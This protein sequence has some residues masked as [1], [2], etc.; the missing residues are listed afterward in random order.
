MDQDFQQTEQ[1]EKWRAENNPEAEATSL[2]STIQVLASLLCLLLTATAVSI[3]VL[4]QTDVKHDEE[5]P[6]ACCFS[7]LSK[8]IPLHFLRDY[9]LTS[10]MC[11]LKAV[12]FKTKKNRQAC[13]NPKQKWV[14]DAMIYLDHHFSP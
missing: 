2:P 11:S 9:Q 14:Q 12:L 7:F 4:A 6:F 1:P 8:T 5:T 13:A 10:D 3:Q